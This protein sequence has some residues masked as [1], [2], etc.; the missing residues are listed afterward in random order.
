[1]K[2]KIGTILEVIMCCVKV[3]PDILGCYAQDLCHT[4]V[5][6]ESWQK[7]AQLSHPMSQNCSA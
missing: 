6:C 2:A 4:S 7:L 1:M 3:R 5:G